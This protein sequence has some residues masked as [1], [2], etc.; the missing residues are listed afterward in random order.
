[1]MLCE[2]RPSLLSQA[3]VENQHFISLVWR[4]CGYLGNNCCPVLYV[5]H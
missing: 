2:I 5:E 1:M 3:S 4:I